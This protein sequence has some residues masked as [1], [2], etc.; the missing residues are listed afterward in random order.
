MNAKQKEMNELLKN[1]RVDDKYVVLTEDRLKQT[2]KNKCKED[3]EVN[4]FIEENPY[5][6]PEE[7]S[8]ITEL[9]IL[10]QFPEKP[11]RRLYYRDIVEKM[12]NNLTDE[13]I[14]VECCKELYNVKFSDK[15]NK[16]SFLMCNTN[17]YILSFILRYRYNT[18]KSNNKYNKENILGRID[19]IDKWCKINI[20]GWGE[21]LLNK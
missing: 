21:Y 4:D 18:R 11:L 3:K 9:M 19:M 10:D 13:E 6:D 15:Q 12:Y 20:D 1:W 16:N 2:Y 14:V 8:K 5:P 17:L 7:M